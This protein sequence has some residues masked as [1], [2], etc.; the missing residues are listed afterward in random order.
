MHVGYSLM[1]PPPTA[2]QASY[3][4]AE[5]KFR[6][7]SPKSALHAKHDLLLHLE[8]TPTNMLKSTSIISRA[9]RSAQIPLVARSFAS[10]AR[11]SLP[12]A[13]LT[14]TAGVDPR[15]LDGE[16][17]LP[18]ANM[19][20]LCEWQSGLWERL[21]KEV[22]SESIRLKSGI[23][24]GSKSKATGLRVRSHACWTLGG[25]RPG[26]DSTD[27]QRVFLTLS[28]KTIYSRRTCILRRR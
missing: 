7:S 4:R 12:S 19:D 15:V 22:R 5:P 24:D 13:P 16:V 1:L 23:S 3:T 20:R 17:L 21:A 10:T 27:V 28:D 6:I 26:K 14:N 11:T 2:C 9:S 18:K 25:Q 8:S